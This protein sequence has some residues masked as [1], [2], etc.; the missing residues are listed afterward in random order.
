[1]GSIYASAVES[2][3]KVLITKLKLRE[4]KQLIRELLETMV[5]D[6]VAKQLL[7]AISPESR[8][9]IDNEIN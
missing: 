9:I 1:M 6:S 8:A 5:P 4:I 3:E 2:K 7:D